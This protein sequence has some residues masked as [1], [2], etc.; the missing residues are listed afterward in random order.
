MSVET[1][2]PP[3]E[4][5]YHLPERHQQRPVIST[6]AAFVMMLPLVVLVWWI[7]LLLFSMRSDQDIH[8]KISPTSGIDWEVTTGKEEKK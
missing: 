8:I 1:P 7:G 5:E 3:K 4:P 2:E 6:G